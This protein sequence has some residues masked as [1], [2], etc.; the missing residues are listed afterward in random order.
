MKQPLSNI[1]YDQDSLAA[2]LKMELQQ[3]NSQQRLST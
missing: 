2:L 1:A 3:Q